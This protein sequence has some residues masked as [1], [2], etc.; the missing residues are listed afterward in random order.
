M[1]LTDEERE[2][3]QCSLTNLMDH[4]SRLCEE[5]EQLRTRLKEYEDRSVPRELEL[6]MKEIGR[7]HV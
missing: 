6:M 4:G 3:V 7:A 1:S 5:N 2:E